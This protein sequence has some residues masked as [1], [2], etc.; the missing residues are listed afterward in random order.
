MPENYRNDTLKK[1]TRVQTRNKCYL[2]TNAN[3]TTLCLVKPATPISNI[4]NKVF[5]LFA[6]LNDFFFLLFWCEMTKALNIKPT[7][8]FFIVFTQIIPKKYFLPLSK[9]LSQIHWQK[10]WEIIISNRFWNIF[11]CCIRF[12]AFP[13]LF[14]K[15]RQAQHNVDEWKMHAIWRGKLT[16]KNFEWSCEKISELFHIFL[17]QEIN[18]TCF[19]S[20]TI[21][22]FYN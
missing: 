17:F 11:H 16:M 14:L 3:F 12:Q 18:L 15:A 4:L 22:F 20:S 5:F 6:S 19:V 7:Y 1:R 21:G 13:Y 9:L 10:K 8:R 2:I